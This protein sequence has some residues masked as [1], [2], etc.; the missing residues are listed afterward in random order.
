M[1]RGTSLRVGLVI[2]GSL[3]TVSGGYLYDRK[4]VE[5]LEH[6]GNRVEVISLPWRNYAR[7]LGDNLSR[8]LLDRLRRLRVDVLL[9]DELNHPSL[10]WLNQRL[11]GSVHYPLVSIVHHLRCNES[12]PIWQN[13]F[14]RSIE[15]SYL[16]SVDAFIFN[17]Q[18]TCQS[19]AQVGIDLQ[20]HPFVVA[21]P[22]GDR[23]RPDIQGFSEKEITQR[24]LQTGPL[25]LLFLGN[26]IPR[27]GLHILLAALELLP[28]QACSLTVVGDFQI[29]EAYTRVIRRQ[30][31]KV[32]LGDRVN[33]CGSLEEEQ[34]I[35]LLG[36]SHLLV[37][38]SYYEGFGIVYLEGMGFGL[39]SIA[40]TSG[41][42]N[43][44]ITHGQNGCLIPPG[45]AT[46]LAGYL[47]ELAH[48]RQ[49]LVA[50]S[51]SARQRYLAHPTWEQSGELIHDFLISLQ[52][53]PG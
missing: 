16:S 29:D 38:P 50:M 6:R 14:Y 47:A 23:L 20:D 42:A 34:L 27:K 11:R 24:A 3:D 17:S 48:N 7:H 36:A 51:L 25:R 21:Y 49:C 30:I 40:T 45:D 15:R 43:E 52:N 32:S 10:F 4:L 53:P 44:L 5:N 8:N 2:Y 22:A 19:V 35:R 12:R 37:V 39:P 13:R 18:T 31:A 46:S 9:Q 33:L 1:T 28:R 26:V 41:A